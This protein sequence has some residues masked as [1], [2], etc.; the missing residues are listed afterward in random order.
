MPRSFQAITRYCP[1]EYGWSEGGTDG[2]GFGLVGVVGVFVP[3]L[4]VGDACVGVVGVGVV[5]SGVV[6]G[7]ASAAAIA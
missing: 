5:G 3:V 4:L 2:A 1:F 6:V 7:D